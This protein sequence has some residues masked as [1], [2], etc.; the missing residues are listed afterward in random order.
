[1]GFVW[2][3]RDRGVCVVREAHQ[4]GEEGVGCVGRVILLDC[5]GQGE[6]HY[7]VQEGALCSHFG[8]PAAWVQ[9]GGEACS[10]AD[11]VFAGA[12]VAGGEV[13]EGEA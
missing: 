12:D 13:V 6:R 1:M 5:E 2:G 7:K 11:R 10:S 4:G 9:E 8:D 3:V